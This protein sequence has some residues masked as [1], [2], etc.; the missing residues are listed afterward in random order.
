LAILLNSEWLSLA[1]KVPQIQRRNE[2]SG[3]RR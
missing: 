3:R 1:L 2:V